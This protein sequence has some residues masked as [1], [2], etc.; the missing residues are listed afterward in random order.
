MASNGATPAARTIS[1]PAVSLAEGQPAR[2]CQKSPTA[3]P[4]CHFCL[5]KFVAVA[6]IAKYRDS[7]LKHVR[8]EIV[9]D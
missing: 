2:D 4:A 5:R 7:L 9:L 8:N 1:N 6:N 3:L